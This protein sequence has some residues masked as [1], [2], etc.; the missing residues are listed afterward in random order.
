MRHSYAATG[1]DEDPF[2]SIPINRPYTSTTK[3]S[4][5]S[6][7]KKQVSVEADEPAIRATNAKL[8][9]ARQSEVAIPEQPWMAA[10]KA[11]ARGARRSGHDPLKVVQLDDEEE[12]EHDLRTN[13]GRRLSYRRKRS[14]R[15]VRSALDDEEAMEEEAGQSQCSC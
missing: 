8:C 5:S 12:V 9:A 7:P 13:R 6:A 15:S 10:I 3:E 11:A 14:E 1:D 4:T 2:D